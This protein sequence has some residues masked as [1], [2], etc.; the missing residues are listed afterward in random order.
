MIYDKNTIVFAHKPSIHNFQDITGNVFN[1]LRVLGYAG[2]IKKASYWWCECDCGNIIK[3]ILSNLKSGDTQSCG[4]RRDEL[5]RS[6]IT[7]G[8]RYT[9]EYRAYLG[10][11]SR[12]NNPKNPSYSHYGQRGVEFRFSSFEEFF[13][14][15]GER[16]SSCYSLNRIDNKG[17]YEVDNIEWATAVAQTRNRHITKTLRWGSETIYLMEAAHRSG[18]AYATIHAR[19]HRGWCD[20]CTVSKPMFETCPHRTILLVNLPS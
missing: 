4:C 15:V 20:E 11:K 10:A 18:I 13:D 9:P 5:A 19:L 8:A 3:A 2:R 6:R 12:C 17:H 7:H 14:A 16:P 1:R